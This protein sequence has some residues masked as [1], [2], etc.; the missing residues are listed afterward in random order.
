MAINYSSG[1]FSGGIPTVNVAGG[2]IAK[3]NPATGMATAPASTPAAPAANAGNAAAWTYFTSDGV[4]YAYNPTSGLYYKLNAATNAWEQ[5]TAPPAT[6]TPTTTPTGQ[7]GQ[8]ALGGAGLAQTEDVYDP[9][10]AFLQMLGLGGRNYYSPQERYNV[11]Q[12]DPLSNLFGIQGRMGTVD[13]SYA[14]SS[15]YFA[16]Y[17]GGVGDV[18]QKARELL[19][20]I[21]GMG[22]E[23]RGQAET[24]Y[25][26]TYSEGE[27]TGSGNVAELQALIQAAL[28]QQL[29]RPGANWMASRLPGEQQLWANTQAGDGGDTFLDYLKQ[30][31]N[32]GS[33]I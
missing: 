25:E 24:V 18:Y 1:G 33:F 2:G 22:T 11:G 13:P 32:L 8:T 14:P 4:Q 28:R 9:F 12:Y 10:T 27:R 29:G 5:T 15:G 21:F 26:P 6:P 3:V 30:K 17:A 19:S 16:D 7:T 31:Y 23:Q 20:G